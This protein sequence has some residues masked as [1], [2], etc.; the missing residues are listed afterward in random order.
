VSAFSPNGTADRSADS[1][2]IYARDPGATERYVL[3][4]RNAGVVDVDDLV[5]IG[6][7]G[8]PVFQLDAV[9]GQPVLSGDPKPLEAIDLPSRATRRLTLEF[10]QG[11]QCPER[12]GTLDAVRLRYSVLGGTY[13]ERI[14]LGDPPTI[15]C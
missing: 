5:V 2:V 6:V 14:P 4:L 15:H 1:Q 3:P 13:V 10:H 11:P 7:E 8:S 12:T 9:L